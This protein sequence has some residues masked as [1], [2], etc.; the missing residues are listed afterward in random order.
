M[1]LSW[2]EIKDRAL[3]FSKEWEGTHS[4]EADAKPF[5]VEFFNV[6]GLNQRKVAAFEHKVKKLGNNDGYIDML[7]KGWLLIEMKSKGKDLSK[8]YGQ[9]KGYI[10]GLQKLDIPKYVLVCDFDTFRLYD[11]EET[12]DE[13]YVEFKLNDFVN[14]VELFGFIAG[15]QKKVYREEDPVNVKAAELMGKLHDRLKEIGYEGHP[16]EIYLVRLLFCLFAEDTNIFNKQEF[17]DFI[18]ERTGEDGSDLAAKIQEIFQVLNTPLDKRFK[19]L[20]EQLNAFPYVGGKLF[21]EILPTAH[22]DSKM[23][24]TLLECCYLDWSKICPK[25]FITICHKV[26]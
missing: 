14:H 12:G 4:E 18:E 20:D 19:N 24:Q 7:W 1:A 9:A 8:A 5:L 25:N 10:H 11:L 16:L 3:A 26:F 15:Y 22:F 2:N 23:R 6:F 17:Q 21:G 13:E